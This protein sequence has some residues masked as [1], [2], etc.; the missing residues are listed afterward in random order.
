[1]SA[2]RTNRPPSPLARRIAAS[3]A[4]YAASTHPLPQLERPR[5]PSG[6]W[7]NGRLSRKSSAVAR[8]QTESTNQPTSVPARQIAVPT[9]CSAIL[10]IQAAISLNGGLSHT[11]TPGGQGSA[12]PSLAGSDHISSAVGQGCSGWAQGSSPKRPSSAG[13]RI[14]AG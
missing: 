8:R 3:A 6:A 2:V 5:L 10:A 9:P 1:M 14:C 4:P 11:R 12:R 7:K 13:A